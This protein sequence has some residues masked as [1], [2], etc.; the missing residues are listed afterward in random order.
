MDFTPELEVAAQ[1]FKTAWQATID[2]G[3]PPP[4]APTTI[5]KKGHGL[6]LRETWAYREGIKTK[7]FSDGAEIGPDDPEISEYVYYNEH[8]TVDTP[9]RPACGI[10]V[11]GPGEKILDELENDIADKEVS[12]F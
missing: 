5:M 7:V 6:T 8:G 11:D 4:N 9:A 1:S 12:I 3:V 10:T 2:A